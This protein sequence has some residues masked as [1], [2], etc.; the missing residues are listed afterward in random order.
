MSFFLIK[1]MLSIPP[2]IPMAFLSYGLCVTLLEPARGITLE[3]AVVSKEREESG[4]Q[5]LYGGKT[6]TLSLCLVKGPS[7]IIF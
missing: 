4:S 6:L 3:A 5:G 1:K 7:C 2:E